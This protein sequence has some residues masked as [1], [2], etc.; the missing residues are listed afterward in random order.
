MLMCHKQVNAFPKAKGIKLD[1]K[2][3][4]GLEAAIPILQK[5]KNQLQVPI[6]LNGDVLPGPNCH[7]LIKVN[8][9]EFFA[10]IQGFPDITISPGW[11]TRK[12]Q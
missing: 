6:W 1:F 7:Y 8:V 10:G 3:I 12:I 11:N 5:M 2:S 9:D 4:E